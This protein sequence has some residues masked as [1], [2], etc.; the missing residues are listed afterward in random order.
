MTLEAQERLCLLQKI[1]D[2]C[3]MGVVAITAT[4]QYRLMLVG[5]RAL[6]SRMAIEANVMGG[7][8]LRLE[9]FWSAMGFVALRAGHLPFPHRVV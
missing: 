7:N 6:I 3:S 5:K 9:I 8:S 1:V 4:L 2:H